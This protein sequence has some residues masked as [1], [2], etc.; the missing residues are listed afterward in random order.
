MS[1]LFSSCSVVMYAGVYTGD[2]S[3]QGTLYSIIPN[4]GQGDFKYTGSVGITGSSRINSA[5]N[6][7]EFTTNA[8]PRIDYSYTN[9]GFSF[10]GSLTD[11]N[12]NRPI[13]SSISTGTTIG[14]LILEGETN[15]RY[16]DTFIIDDDPGVNYQFSSNPKFPSPGDYNV[17]TFQ[18]DDSGTTSDGK[19]QIDLKWNAGNVPDNVVG[20]ISF[21]ISG[22]IAYNDTTPDLARVMFVDFRNTGL[23][24]NLE[25]DE[26]DIFINPAEYPNAK[27]NADSASLLVRTAYDTEITDIGDGWLRLSA[28]GRIND[29]ISSTSLTRFK[30]Y[31]STGD[32]NN[33]L[34]DEFNYAGSGSAPGQPP[35]NPDPPIF[36]I[37]NLQLELIE[38]D[39]T[40]SLSGSSRTSNPLAFIPASSYTPTS[41]SAI[42][43]PSESLEVPLTS[44][45]VSSI[46]TSQNQG[47]IITRFAW[48]PVSGSNEATSNHF[49]LLKTGS[50]STTDFLRIDGRG[51]FHRDETGTL[52]EFATQSSQVPYLTQSGS[53]FPSTFHNYAFTW[54][55]SEMSCSIDSG[56]IIS[57]SNNIWTGSASPAEQL[58]YIG[59]VMGIS[60]NTQVRLQYIMVSPH[61]FDADALQNATTGSI[62]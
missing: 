6:F 47:T 1:T 34:L 32:P 49:A 18:E 60:N 43:K 50:A 19:H 41:A 55:G 62:V 53:L 12:T 10:I 2:S 8:T 38:G 45:T 31:T 24:E 48:T 46:L 56:S 14:N 29:M 30:L 3:T 21:C 61:K 7:T 27:V 4:S 22:G 57:S 17:I 15:N 16:I 26:E 35:T 51:I 13:T 25:L 20:K 28:L 36:S 52:K 42:T 40:S 44:S 33:N 11:Y 5:L 37:A 39:I 9:E 54:S 23:F 58:D 59:G